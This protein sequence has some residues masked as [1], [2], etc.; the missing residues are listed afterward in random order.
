K[1]YLVILEFAGLSTNAKDITNFVEDNTNVKTI[2][3]DH[4]PHQNEVQVYNKEHILN[5]PTA[6]QDFEC[7]TSC[8]Q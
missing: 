3:V 5:D 4:L 7:R 1:L 8:V 2:I 6:F